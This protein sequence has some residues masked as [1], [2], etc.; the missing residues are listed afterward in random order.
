MKDDHMGTDPAH[1][2]PQELSLS[3]WM[4]FNYVDRYTLPDVAAITYVAPHKKLR[5]GRCRDAASAVGRCRPPDMKRPGAG[6]GLKVFHWKRV[7]L[8]GAAT[9]MGVPAR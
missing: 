1:P 6:P 3:N 7:G 5:A 2:S 8:G 4:R 9:L